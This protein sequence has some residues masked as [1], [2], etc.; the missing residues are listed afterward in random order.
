MK[1]ILIIDYQMS[2]MFSIKNALI[3]LGYDCIVSNNKK[4]LME[5]D[6]AILPG[7]GAFPEAMNQLHKLDLVEPI[8]E[9]VNKSKKIIGICLGMHLLYE[10]SDEFKETRGLALIKGSV[11]KINETK[12]NILVPHIG[13]NKVKLNNTNE[14]SKYDNKRFY[15][16]HSYYC[17]NDNEN[18][19]IMQTDYSSLN[20]TSMIKKKNI[21]ACQFHPEKSGIQGLSLLN[22]II[23]K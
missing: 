22:D 20:F 8:K 4:H 1:K 6:I 15:F 18:D 11:K 10:V 17:K 2:N 13:W 9:F 12:K 14:Y 5:A 23:S 21:Y 16:V 3:S 19:I 7:V